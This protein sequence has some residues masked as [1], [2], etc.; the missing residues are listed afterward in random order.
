MNYSRSLCLFAH[1]GVQHILCCVF[2][3]FFFVLRTLYCQFSG[4]P[5]F[6]LTYEATVFPSNISR[7]PR[8]LPKYVNIEAVLRYCLGTRSL[9]MSG[10]T[11]DVKY[12]CVT[13]QCKESAVIMYRLWKLN[14]KRLDGKN[15]RRKASCIDLV[16]V[17]VKYPLPESVGQVLG[18]VRKVG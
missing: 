2:V 16:D 11:M 13:A 15:F 10:S 8:F 12:W 18:V 3:L 6:V 4:L 7:L 5:I 17:C 14:Q 1:N 9:H